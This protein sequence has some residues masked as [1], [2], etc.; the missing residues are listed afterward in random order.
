MEHSNQRNVIKH[1]KLP[2]KEYFAYFCYGFGQCFS[3][4][5]LGTFI[6]YFYTDIL[7]VTAVASSVIFLIARVWDA[8]NDPIVAGIMDSRRTKT[9][10]FHGYFKIMPILVIVST[11]ICFL[12]PNLSYSGKVLYA[13]VTYI[14]WGTIYT[15]SDIPFWSIASVMS[16]NAQDRTKLLTYANMGVYGGI[17]FVTLVVP[18]L[19]SWLQD[20]GLSVA[21]SFLL[22]VCILMVASFILMMY[23]YFHIKERVHSTNDEKIAIKDI[24]E[25]L[26]AN[27]YLFKIVVI[28]FLNIFNNIV[29]GIIIYFFTYNMNAPELMSAF[30]VISTLSALG[31]FFIPLLTNYFKKRNIL[32]T[33]LGLDILFRIAFY[34]IGYQSTPLVIFFLAVTQTLYASTGPLISA[35]LSETIEYSEVKTGKR[36]EAITFTGQ[37]FTGKLSTALAGASTG[38]ILTLLGYQPNVSQSPQTLHGL[39]LVISILPALG[40][41]IRILLLLTYDYTE[42]EYNQNLAILAKR[43]GIAHKTHYKEA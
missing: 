27:K 23:G 36:F 22:T 43:K 13:A 19:A 11:I 32:I 40:S 26:Q 5:L 20:Y 1:E 35:M 29:Q 16:T 31:F 18:I 2:V 38:L 8:V 24:F 37:T 9:G 7:G 25:S 17:G 6:L 15:M 39:F 12:S 3:F 10:K 30:G 34:L 33:I 28:F 14:L 4:G 42:E 41:F 21:N